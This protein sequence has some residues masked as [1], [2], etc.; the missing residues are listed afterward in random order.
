MLR[1]VVEERVDVTVEVVEEVVVKVVVVVVV[2]IVEEAL[3]SLEIIE[4]LLLRLLNVRVC[5]SFVDSE[6][7]KVSEDKGTDLANFEV[8]GIVLVVVVVEVVL[9]V[10]IVKGKLEVMVAAEAIMG[11]IK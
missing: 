6:E 8:D 1:I 4:M 3:M 9:V 5:I 11:L 2:A 10:K 7:R